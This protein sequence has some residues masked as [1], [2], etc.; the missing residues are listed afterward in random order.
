[1]NTNLAFSLPATRNKRKK[2]KKKVNELSRSNFLDL[3]A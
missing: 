1:M 2:K 3:A